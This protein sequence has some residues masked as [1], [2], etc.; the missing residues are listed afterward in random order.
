MTSEVAHVPFESQP[1]PPAPEV[2][3][4]PRVWPA[5]VLIGLFW[6]FT[7][8]CRW[9]EMPLFVRFMSQLLS[10]SLLLLLFTGWWLV[11]RRRGWV[12]R[13]L[14]LG[15]VASGGVAAAFLADRTLPVITLLLLA[16]PWVFTAWAVW[17]VVARGAGRLTRRL[18]LVAMLFLAWGAFTLVRMNG[19]TGDLDPDIHWRWSRTPEDLYRAERTAAGGQAADGSARVVPASAPPLQPGDW[20]AFRGPERD[21]AVHGVRIAT[22]WDTNPPRQ[23]W[24][25]RVGPAWSSVAVVGDR[26]FTQ[27]QRGDAEAVVCLDA[28]SGREVWAHEDAVRFWDAQSG[29]GPRATPT[30]ADGR[31]YALGGRGTLNCL[32]AATGE[33]KWSHDITADSGA[34]VP[35]W[36]FS[37]SP[38]VV[39]GVVVVFAGGEGPKG[40]LAYHAD[41]G[42]PA[43]S[44][45][46]GRNSYSSPQPATLGGQPQVLFLSDGG[47]TAVDPASGA[48]L[49]EHPG[50][51][52]GMPPSIQPHPVGD[53]QVLCP[54]TKDP[55]LEL[56]DVSPGEPSGSPARHW[57]SKDLKPSYNDFVVHDGS[58]YGFDGSLFCCVDVKTGK[59]R[60]KEGRYGHGQVLLLADQPVLLV[61]TETGEAV[62]VATNP[63]RHEEL[64]RFQAVNGKTWNHPVIA[65]GRL[66]VRNA[67]EMAC[68]ELSPLPAK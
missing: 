4:R 53:A 8:G 37:C 57:T 67:E 3:Q 23:I 14:G 1:V 54:I 26:L 12:E 30:L 29:A 51:G 24:R 44:A 48:V 45:A 11:N 47:L 31:V 15:A 40:L 63:D 39:Q 6:A 65:H 56:I 20:P 42:E 5:V 61:T 38:L 13:I 43:W 10:V 52:P 19:L 17:L 7:L 18:G 49:W 60:W 62:L 64:G 22:D 50:A 35:I 32:D 33:R 41:S 59:R 27:E 46:T 28:A 2:V 34:K 58:L 16:V 66:Y 21:G 36:G 55:G 25:R 9:V 68:Y